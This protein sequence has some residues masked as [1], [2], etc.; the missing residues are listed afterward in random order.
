MREIRPVEV[1]NVQLSYMIGVIPK[2]ETQR[3]K[4]ILFR[5]TKGNIFN[6]CEEIAAESLPI[7][8]REDPSSILN[9]AFFLIIYRSGESG[10]LGTKLVKIC[11]SFGANRS[12][13]VCFFTESAKRFDMPK[14][15]DSFN[16]KLEEID[17][18]ISDTENVRLKPS[19]WFIQGFSSSTISPNWGLRTC[20]RA[21][22]SLTTSFDEVLPKLNGNFFKGKMCSVIEEYRMY[23]AKEKHLFQNMNLL[24]EKNHIYHGY[25][26]IPRIHEEQVMSILRDLS[27]TN[28]NIVSGQIQEASFGSLMRPPT[29][30]RTNDF[31]N[32]FQVRKRQASLYPTLLG[33]R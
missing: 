8:A 15:M 11:E 20:W 5:V 3:F 9:K 23:V 7:E 29:Y 22:P 27:K 16:K 10:A 21:S 2:E 30:F 28:K 12:Q 26:W 13:F 24:R 4:R 19:A 14:S 31:T 17:I 33:N 25:C 6:L 32:V 1:S 18:G